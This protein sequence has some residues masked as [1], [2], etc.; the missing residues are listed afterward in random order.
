MINTRNILSKYFFNSLNS[1]RMKKNLLKIRLLLVNLLKNVIINKLSWILTFDDDYFKFVAFHICFYCA[2]IS[3]L[4]ASNWLL[5]SF[6]TVDSS[7]HILI[8]ILSI[9]SSKF[10]NF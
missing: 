5:I 1:K 2:E 10:L 3:A 8:S 6:F 7:E 9:F 4:I